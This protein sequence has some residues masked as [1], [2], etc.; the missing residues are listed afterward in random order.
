LEEYQIEPPFTTAQAYCPEADIAT[1]DH[2]KELVF[3]VVHVCP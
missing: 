3:A 1:E 2:V